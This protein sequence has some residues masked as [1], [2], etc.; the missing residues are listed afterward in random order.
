MSAVEAPEL[1]TSRQIKSQP[2]NV[3]NFCS[4]EPKPVAEPA[5]PP[6]PLPLGRRSS[7]PSRETCGV[8]DEGLRLCPFPRESREWKRISERLLR[9]DERVG[10]RGP[11]GSTCLPFPSWIPD[12]T[13]HLPIC[14]EG[15]RE[16]ERAGGGG[17]GGDGRGSRTHI[18][19]VSDRHGVPG[20]KCWAAKEGAWAGAL[21]DPKGGPQDEGS[22]E[23]RGCGLHRQWQ[24]LDWTLYLLC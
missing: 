21:W 7:H 14:S 11:E 20:V 3:L 13:P 15:R 6:A 9:T 17:W 12:Q 16:R 2:I 23:V 8:C 18:H 1:G 5:L 10:G 24:K 19:L 4:Q 22:P